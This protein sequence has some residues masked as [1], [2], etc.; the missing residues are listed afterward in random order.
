MIVCPCLKH[1]RVVA[2][3]R[4]R[5]VS[6][7]VCLLEA[8]YCLLVQ[9]R[10]AQRSQVL[11]P[12][13]VASQLPSPR[14]A[15]AAWRARVSSPRRQVFEATLMGELAVLAS[16]RTVGVTAASAGV[17]TALSEL[18]LR[19]EA[20]SGVDAIVKVCC[21]MVVYAYREGPHPYPH[22][23]R[24]HLRGSPCIAADA[25]SHCVAPAT[26]LGTPAI[27]LTTS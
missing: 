10:A 19:H 4:V 11:F 6:Y 23:S 15:P 26:L 22:P 14:A 18:A 7:S 24:G 8:Q 1:Y 13:V 5:G 16:A 20:Y 17:V 12:H 25:K 2:H 21:A 3:H 27:S 9:R